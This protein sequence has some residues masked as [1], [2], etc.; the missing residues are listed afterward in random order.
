VEG[1]FRD[2]VFTGQTDNAI[3]IDKGCSLYTFLNVTFDHTRPLFIASLDH[4]H[5]LGANFIGCKF[6]NMPNGTFKSYFRDKLYIAMLHIEN[7]TFD[8]VS[9]V[10]D[11]LQD[12]VINGKVIQ[13]SGSTDSKVSSIRIIDFILK[14]SR[15]LVHLAS[16]PPLFGGFAK[17]AL[18]PSHHPGLERVTKQC[19]SDKACN[20]EKK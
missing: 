18:S 10:P 13:W 12:S 19:R 8:S 7:M 16:A 3:F 1:L 5:P 6:I 14:V 20:T 17:H 4:Y 11:F 15:P 2:C 9:K